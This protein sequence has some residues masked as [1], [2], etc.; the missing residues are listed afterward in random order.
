[1]KKEIKSCPFCGDLAECVAENL[2]N[3]I[4][5]KVECSLCFSRTNY[6]NHPTIAIEKWNQR[7]N[8]INEDLLK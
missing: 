2:D 1:M 6:Y 8:K 4:K 7:L 5:Y 3:E